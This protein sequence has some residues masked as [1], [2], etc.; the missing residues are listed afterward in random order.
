MTVLTSE[1]QCGLSIH[2]RTISTCRQICSTDRLGFI[3]FL[4]IIGVFVCLEA[5]QLKVVYIC[6]CTCYRKRT[7]YSV[8]FDHTWDL[9]G[10]WQ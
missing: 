8:K 10:D 7:K 5:N 1:Q 2:S 9:L 3:A 4:H 6:F